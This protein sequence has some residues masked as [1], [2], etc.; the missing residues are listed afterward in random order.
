LVADADNLVTV[1][2]KCYRARLNGRELEYVEFFWRNLSEIPEG[3]R[4]PSHGR[5]AL[6]VPRARRIIAVEYVGLRPTY[7]IEMAGEH[8][9]FVANGLVTHN[10]QV[11]QRYVNVAR[12]VERP[13]FQV[14]P[15]LHA[16]FEARIDEA[17][18][19]YAALTEALRVRRAAG[20]PAFAG[21]RRTD[22]RKAVQQAARALLPN[23]TEAPIAVTGNTR[24]WRHIIAMRCSPHAEPEI[25]R[26][27]HRLWVG[28]RSVEPELFGDFAEEALPDGS[29]ALRTEWPK[30]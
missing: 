22:Q 16:A 10:S 3:R 30:V 29:V 25:R 11:S 23:E 14:V 20:D 15:E 24:A 5:G 12:F 8:K 2:R 27:M 17:A 28:L 21:L 13:E 18:R 6:L 1:C 7:D 19:Q 9:N 4:Q 26:A